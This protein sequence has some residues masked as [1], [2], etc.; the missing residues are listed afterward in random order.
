MDDVDIESNL[1][2]YATEFLESYASAI[3]K[4]TALAVL[5]TS[6]DFYMF[7]LADLDQA[8]AVLENVDEDTARSPKKE[9]SSHSLRLAH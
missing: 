2:T 5:C 9:K 6:S 7:F 1:I 4:D 3:D 8:V